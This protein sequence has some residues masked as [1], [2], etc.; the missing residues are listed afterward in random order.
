MDA[1]DRETNPLMQRR[2]GGQGFGRRAVF[3]RAG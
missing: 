2:P 3:G 1:F